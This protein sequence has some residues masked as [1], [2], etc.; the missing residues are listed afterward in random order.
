MNKLKI[1]KLKLFKSDETSS[2]TLNLDSGDSSEKEKNNNER[3]F[4]KI[5]QTFEKYLQKTNSCLKDNHKLRDSMLKQD[6]YSKIEAGLN[7]NSVILDSLAY[8]YYLEDQIVLKK[9]DLLLSKMP[10][11]FL[12]MLR[13][14]RKQNELFKK[15]IQD[16]QQS[17]SKSFKQVKN[18]H[19]FR[20]INHNHSKSSGNLRIFRIKSFFLI[21][22]F[23]FF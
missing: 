21:N 3:K 22:N 15:S 18:G 14:R 20:N 9:T 12:N 6:Q 4:V 23:G 13:N 1:P 5:E 11:K 19:L 2:T 17:N 10:D 7:K 16:K 8:A